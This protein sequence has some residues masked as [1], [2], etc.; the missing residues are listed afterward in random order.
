MLGILA[1]GLAWAWRAIDLPVLIRSMCLRQRGMFGHGSLETP[2]GIMFFNCLIICFA[3]LFD[4]S[5]IEYLLINLFNVKF[6]LMDFKNS[7]YLDLYYAIKHQLL[8]PPRTASKKCLTR[9]YSH[10]INNIQK[11]CWPL[12]A[13]A[14]LRWTGING[15][16]S[17]SR[18]KIIFG[19]I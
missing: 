7:Y 6:S 10:D 9:Q 11:R 15:D 5:C 1:S 8:K 3:S 18:L 19:N 12:W 13:G 14:H 17:E 4:Y 2:P 16:V